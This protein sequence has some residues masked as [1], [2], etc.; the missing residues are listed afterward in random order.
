[1]QLRWSRFIAWWERRP[2]L[3]DAM[4]MLASLVPVVAVANL[5]LW[6]RHDIEGRRP[7]IWFWIVVVIVVLPVAWRRSDPG[8]AT[9]VGLTAYCV[10]VIAGFGELGLFIPAVILAHTL[11]NHVPAPQ[12]SRIV[13]TLGVVGS[14][15]IIVRIFGAGLDAANLLVVAA[16][17]RGQSVRN[18]RDYLVELLR[19]V[20]TADA[21]A[22]DEARL[23]VSA[24]RAR[25]ARDL[26]DVV[27]HGMSVM[28]VQAGAARR[29]LDDDRGAARDALLNIE[30]TGRSSLG[31]MR[32]LLGVLRDDPCPDEEAIMVAPQLGIREISTLV[33]SVRDAGRTVTLRLDPMS[34]GLPEVIG[35]TIY[36]IVQEALTNTLKHAGPA[37]VTVEVR[38]ADGRVF[39]V[40]RDDGRGSAAPNDGS[41]HGL[42]GMAER[43][44]VFEGE[45]RAGPARAGG[46][47]VFA[48]LPVDVVDRVNSQP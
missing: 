9:I 33:A 39:T 18:H 47:E 15:A 35:V 37:A 22:A 36:R 41:G 17:F 34:N 46:Y 20:E 48:S 44:G 5:S 23:A 14:V 12:R 1:M 31:E 24:E 11:G 19:R 45:L 8:P 21:L 32:A 6:D 3:A 4:L 10:M 30:A 40:V 38:V 28:V 13:R 26:H 25:I 42:V 43:V 29:V 27:A 7:D 16:F 2:R